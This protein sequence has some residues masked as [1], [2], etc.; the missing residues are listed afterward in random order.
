M[1]WTPLVPSGD[2]PPVGGVSLGLKRSDILPLLQPVALE[3]EK[4]LCIS[5]EEIYVKHFFSQGVLKSI[6][7]AFFNMNS[8][9]LLHYISRNVTLTVAT[10]AVYTSVILPGNFKV[11]FIK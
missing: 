11:V 8:R 1:N 5:S 6:S 9:G 4:H 7:G 2:P 3:S 10:V